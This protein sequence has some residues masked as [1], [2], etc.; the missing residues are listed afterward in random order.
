[1]RMSEFSTAVYTQLY[2]CSTAVYTA[3]LVQLRIP[4]NSGPHSAPKTGAP[5]AVQTSFGG[6]AVRRATHVRASHDASSKV[7]HVN[8]PESSTV[9]LAM[10]KSR[11]LKL[12]AFDEYCRFDT[13]AHF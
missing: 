10:R 12:L 4:F 1:M 2:Y 6:D 5:N 8:P 7:F 3:A 11:V 9:F 13:S